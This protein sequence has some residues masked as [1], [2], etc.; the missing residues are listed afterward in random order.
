MQ[1]Q[2]CIRLR[3]KIHCGKPYYIVP[4]CH[5]DISGLPAIL[6]FADS[7]IPQKDLEKSYLKK[8]TFLTTYLDVFEGTLEPLHYIY[9]KL[10]LFADIFNKRNEITQKTIKFSPDGIKIFSQE[11]ELDMDYLSSGEKMISLCSTTMHSLS[12]QNYAKR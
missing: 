12:V 7:V 1:A 6:E 3:E 5:K 4:R 10:K 8:A 9:E 2:T 11:D